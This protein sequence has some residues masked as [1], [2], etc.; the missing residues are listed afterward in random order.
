MSFWSIGAW[1]LII[2][3]GLAA[4]FGLHRLALRL[5]QRGWL[6]YKHK[7]PSS[8]AVS[9]GKRNE[10]QFRCVQPRVPNGASCSRHP[11]IRWSR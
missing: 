4:L 9:C 7:K 2:I 1:C 8:S 5:E 10:D 6:F 11:Q 3:S